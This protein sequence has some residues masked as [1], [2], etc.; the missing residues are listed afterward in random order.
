LAGNFTTDFIEKSK[1]LERVSPQVF[2]EKP[3]EK[4]INEEEIAKIVYQI[5]KLLK[6]KKEIEPQ[7]VSNWQVAE[8]LK[9]LE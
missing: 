9:M 6:E 7:E 1:I 2:I 5:Y 3:L 8:R 4:E